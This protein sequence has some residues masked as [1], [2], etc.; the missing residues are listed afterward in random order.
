MR[1]EFDDQTACLASLDAAKL[2]RVPVRLLVRGEFRGLEAGAFEA[3]ARQ[4]AADW[5]RRLRIDAPTV[6]EG[7]GHYIQRDKPNEVVDAIA[8][9]AASSARHARW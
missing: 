1:R 9:A 3:A 8:S 2:P 4:L 7:A 5:T 6:V